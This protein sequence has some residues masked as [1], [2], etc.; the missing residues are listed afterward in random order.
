MT[1][2]LIYFG[3]LMFVDMSRTDDK[4]TNQKL[5]PK[6]WDQT[7]VDFLVSNNFEDLDYDG[8]ICGQFRWTY[9][10]GHECYCPNQKIL[11]HP[12]CP[13]AIVRTIFGQVENLVKTCKKYDNGHLEWEGEGESIRTITWMD[14]DND[15]CVDEHEFMNCNRKDYYLRWMMFGEKCPEGWGEGYG[16]FYYGMHEFN[17]LPPNASGSEYNI[18]SK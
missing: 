17:N 12:K 1:G 15:D 8:K 6:V 14:L 18:T 7:W 4:V 3:C 11:T 5:H 2:R 9:A 16:G 13:K 10:Y